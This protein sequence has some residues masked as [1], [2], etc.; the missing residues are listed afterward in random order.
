MTH[1]LRMTDLVYYLYREY[2]WQCYCPCTMD[3]GRLYVTLVR[4]ILSTRPDR[5]YMSLQGS[6]LE[7]MQEMYLC[8]IIPYMYWIQLEP[9]SM[10]IWLKI[11]WNLD[12]ARQR[13]THING[14]V[15][16]SVIFN[17]TLTSSTPQKITIW[18]RITLWGRLLLMVPSVLHMLCLIISIGESFGCHAG[19]VFVFYNTL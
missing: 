9:S 4:H 15:H 7:L 5:R 14:N 2:I 10:S 17:C 3:Y 18:L 11:W 6:H 8:F 1:Q 19:N 12:I 16:M 13:L